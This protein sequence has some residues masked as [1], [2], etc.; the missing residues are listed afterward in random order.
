MKLA[1]LTSS[2]TS[3]VEAPISIASATF[4][5]WDVDPEAS[6]VEK[7]FVS[8]PTI[9]K[10]EIKELKRVWLENKTKQQGFH[11]LYV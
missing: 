7:C 4:A 8:E 5:A 2:S 11:F 1:A 6:F 9:G 3:S 10:L